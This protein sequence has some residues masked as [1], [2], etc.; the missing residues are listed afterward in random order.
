[1]R[2]RL[3]CLFK[4]KTESKKY[5]NRLITRPNMKPVNTNVAALLLLLFLW[6][7]LHLV[8][9]QPAS[10]ADP[11]FL[12][13]VGLI[14]VC[15]LIVALS[16]NSVPYE[17]E[18]H[19]RQIIREVPLFGGLFEFLFIDTGLLYAMCIAILLLTPVYLLVAA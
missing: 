13:V 16:W 9:R 5:R 7:M 6:T 8:L 1:M 2:I 17:T 14:D 11:S 18:Y 15:A 10:T 19:M 12:N 4:Q 3:L